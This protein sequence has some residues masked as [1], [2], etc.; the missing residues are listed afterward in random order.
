MFLTFL[1]W[2]IVFLFNFSGDL[3]ASCAI[4]CSMERPCFKTDPVV[5]CPGQSEQRNFCCVRVADWV[6]ARICCVILF[7]LNYYILYNNIL[8]NYCIK[9]ECQKSATVFHVGCRLVYPQNYCFVR[10]S[11]R[12]AKKRCPLVAGASA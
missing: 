3:G 8:Q 7:V 1:K 12:C 6:V 5:S 11:M 10:F 9:L 4:T 2:M